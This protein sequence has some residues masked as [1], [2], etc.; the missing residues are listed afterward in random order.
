V[1]FDTRYCQILQGHENWI[2][3]DPNLHA[4]MTRPYRA[5]GNRMLIFSTRK[6]ST[7]IYEATAKFVV[8]LSPRPDSSRAALAALRSRDRFLRT[9]VDLPT[10]DSAVRQTAQLAPNDAQTEFE[11]LQ[12]VF[13]YCS[14][15]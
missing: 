7:A 10:T 8:R 9:E 4:K 14:E 1:P 3:T 11:R 13:D 2:V 15:I 5:T 6:A 12:W